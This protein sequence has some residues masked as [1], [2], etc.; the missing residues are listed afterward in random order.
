MSAR[1]ERYSAEPEAESKQ[2]LRNNT[3]SY[4][5]GP[6]NSPSEQPPPVH[7]DLLP[8]LRSKFP[9]VPPGETWSH[10]QAII[11]LA[12]VWGQQEL[13]EHLGSIHNS[14]EK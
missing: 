10:E 3:P 13:I 11:A 14:K 4:A 6:P 2:G 9:N 5:P 12:K 8:Y 1:V 7:P